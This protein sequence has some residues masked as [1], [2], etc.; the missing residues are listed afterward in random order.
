MPRLP[1]WLNWKSLLRWLAIAIGAFIG[2]LIL[3]AIG[4][5]DLSNLQN[6]LNSYALVALSLLG[7]SWFVASLIAIR[8]QG[9]A[10]RIFLINAPLT[11][12]CIILFDA[13][14]VIEL[15]SRMAVATLFLLPLYLPLLAHTWRRASIL[16]SISAFAS[17]LLLVLPP[18][19]PISTSLLPVIATAS[20]IILAFGWFW[21]AA[22]KLNW[23][24]LLQSSPPKSLMRRTAKI[25]IAAFAFAILYLGCLISVS[26]LLPT[27]HDGCNYFPL[28]NQ[29]RNSRHAAFT[30]RIVYLHPDPNHSVRGDLAAESAIG[31]VEHNFWGA[32]RW[33]WHLVL[34]T[35]SRFVEGEMYF[36]EGERTEGL[37]TRFLP[38]EVAHTCGWTRQAG[39][40]S[41]ELH[42]LNHPP[43]KPSTIVGQVYRSKE[44]TSG[45]GITRPP[46]P[47]AKVI[48]SGPTGS[49]T[50][51]TDSQGIYEVDGL[52]PADYTVSV[53]LP[54]TEYAA[55]DI[56][57]MLTLQASPIASGEFP[58]TSNGSLEGR[59]T[60]SAGQPVQVWL[61]IGTSAGHGIRFERR[62]RFAIKTS[63]RSD[64]RGFFH[65]DHIPE[66]DYRITTN[67]AGPDKPPLTNSTISASIHLAPAQ[68]I[69]HLSL[70]AIREK[71]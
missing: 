20:L 26:L 2:F 62:S 52:A 61:Y 55:P 66:G 28:F 10:A 43:A 32:P 71:R 25:I 34:L 39:Y 64:S 45:G 42:L 7:S 56:I 69:S 68:H 70:H 13:N 6:D 4:R 46:Y 51:T 37:I 9:L 50:A 59:V 1:I 14:D 40:A 18:L 30:A 58:V 21:F 36:F 49:I 22:H 67:L 41:L 5:F 8:N 31:V 29:P 54:D 47:G 11:I 57:P 38:F 12:F 23:P 65:F 15:A 16:F 63:V 17:A 44:L 27:M 33:P 60:N 24:P 35:G 48:V 3:L 19:R 53:V